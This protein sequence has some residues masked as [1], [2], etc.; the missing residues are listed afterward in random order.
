MT[1]YAEFVDHDVRLIILKALADET[2][3]SLNDS[4]LQAVLETFG[5]SKTRDYVRNQITWLEAEVG[6]VK[7]RPAGSTI[8]ATLT[9]D[10]LD[11]VEHR[12]VL[13]GVKRP[14]LR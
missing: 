13:Q 1:S 4:L 14:S 7:T 11:H 6:A 9:Q 10:G 3:R 8:I 2:N 12:R 5:H